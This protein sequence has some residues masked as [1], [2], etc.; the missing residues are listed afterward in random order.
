MSDL[1]G[2]FNKALD[3]RPNLVLSRSREVFFGHVGPREAEYLLVFVPRL[4]E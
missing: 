3:V 1:F 2:P 4:S